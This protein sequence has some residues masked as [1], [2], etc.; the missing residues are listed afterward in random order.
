MSTGFCNTV[1]KASGIGG[2]WI[3]GLQALHHPSFS[4]CLTARSKLPVRTDFHQ[5]E[6]L[7]S[8][9]EGSLGRSMVDRDQREGVVMNPDDL[10][11][12]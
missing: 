6:V 10:G 2:G 11:A 9:G 12:S 5:V 3:A 1:F 4:T 7:S 8:L